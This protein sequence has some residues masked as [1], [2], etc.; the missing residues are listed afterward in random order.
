[1]I[2]RLIGAQASFLLSYFL[3]NLLSMLVMMALIG[4]RQLL[5]LLKSH[6]YV[7]SGTPRPLSCVRCSHRLRGLGYG[8]AEKLSN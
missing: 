7:L 6:R 4:E 5:Y 3:W 8:K 1:M 2:S